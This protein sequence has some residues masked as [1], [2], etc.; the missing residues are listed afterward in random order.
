[1]ITKRDGRHV[2][3]DG[4]RIRIAIA[5]AAYDNK[6]GWTPDKPFPPYVKDIVQYVWDENEAYE[7]NVEEI[8]NIVEKQLMKYDPETARAYVRYRY[9]KECIREQKNE[10]FALLGEKIEA[11]NVQNQNANVDEYSFGGRK[12]EADNIIMKQY[13]LDYCVSDMAREN[14]QDPISKASI[15]QHSA[16]FM[17]QLSHPY[18]TTG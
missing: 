8:Q 3:F 18:M 2:E 16:L 14:H 17:V 12:G 5:K 9:R 10:F 11:T 6:G 15:L 4:N 7:L 13:A 1:M